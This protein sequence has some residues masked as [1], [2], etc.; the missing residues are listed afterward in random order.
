MMKLCECGC[1]DPAPISTK[2]YSRIGVRKGEPFRF[3]KYH[4]QKTY[5]KGYLPE[6][7]GYLTSCWIWQGKKVRGYGRRSITEKDALE[8][9]KK[10]ASI[11]AH[12]FMWEKEHGRKPSEMILHHRCEQRDCV[13]PDHLLLVTSDD[14]SKIHHTGNHY[15]KKLT[16][17]KANEIRTLREDGCTYETIAR[18]YN[19][20][21]SNIA[22]IIKN[23]IW[24]VSIHT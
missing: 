16:M 20:N 23:R 7:R 21:K 13:R 18:M 8:R 3:I 24:K 1:G 15:S 2:T 11:Y 5:S 10:D 22:A 14:H 6:N 17:E 4:H 9:G 19:V 12:V